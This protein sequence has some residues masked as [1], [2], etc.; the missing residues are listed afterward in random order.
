[1]VSTTSNVTAVFRQEEATLL[2]LGGEYEPIFTLVH[3]RDGA[4][5][6][7]MVEVCGLEPLVTSFHRRTLLTNQPLLPPSLQA[8]QHQHAASPWALV[9]ALAFLLGRPATAPTMPLLNLRLALLLSLATSGKERLHLL[10]L[11]P[12]LVFAHRLLHDAIALASRRALHSH[13]L[14][15]GGV[16]AKDATGVRC[17]QAGALHRAQGGVV[18]LGELAALAPATRQ[19]VV[20][21]LDTAT[22]PCPTLPRSPPTTEPLTTAVWGLAEGSSST[23]HRTIKNIKSFYNVFG[24]V[25]HVE[26][27]DEEVVRHCLLAQDTAP[28]LPS[29]ELAALV[30]EVR[31]RAVTL[32]GA[33]RRLLRGYYLASRRLRG[34]VG[35]PRSA[36]GALLLMATAHTRLAMRTEGEEE[37]GAMSCLMLETSLAAAPGGQAMVELPPAP[38]SMDHL[39]GCTR[40][41]EMRGFLERI[42][43]FV[44]NFGPQ[45]K[46]EEEEGW[47]EE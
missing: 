38:T 31:H 36:I 23:L 10:V 2:H 32:S 12:D 46:G 33:C 20:A 26:V 34:G 4:D 15:L 43:R 11:G 18:Y 39:L 41:M 29:E 6:R 35:M 42:K 44:A 9:T 3:E 16:L 7:V 27:E 22:V 5:R 24:L 40:D 19:Q 17:V 45:D 37:D 14:P 30:E 28:A 21:A 47:P 25:A 8:L 13:A 1:V